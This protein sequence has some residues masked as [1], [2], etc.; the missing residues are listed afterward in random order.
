[1]R[2]LCV[3]SDIALINLAC[4]CVQC[5]PPSVTDT[6]S[7]AFLPLA[8]VTFTRP[9]A[10]GR[11][12]RVPDVVHAHVQPADNLGDR[13]DDAPGKWDL[14]DVVVRQVARSSPGTR[15]DGKQLLLGLVADSVPLAVD[16]AISVTDALLHGAGR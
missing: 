3:V 2:T 1:M 12:A 9:L 16:A 4:L 6:E 14:A 5:T 7:R 15:H 10:A 13:G 11:Q 8:P